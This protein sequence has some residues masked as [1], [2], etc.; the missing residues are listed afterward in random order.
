MKVRTVAVMLALMVF[1][2]GVGRW[3][4]TAPTPPI[5]IPSKEPVPEPTQEPSPGPASTPNFATLSSSKPDGVP[6]MAPYS[7]FGKDVEHVMPED[8]EATIFRADWREGLTPEQ[9]AL[10]AEGLVRSGLDDI[11]LCRPGY[12]CH[13]TIRYRHDEQ[14]ES[15]DLPHAVWLHA[16]FT[17][18]AGHSEY[19]WYQE[20]SDSSK[21]WVMTDSGWRYDGATEELPDMDKRTQSKL[22]AS[23]FL[24]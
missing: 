22:I 8:T 10:Y 1:A 17:T 12:T 5:R 6:G 2:W 3:S 19:Y 13:A 15:S 24:E 23:S 4:A 11:G 18:R 16:T 21:V 9:V 14:N 7:G 20:R